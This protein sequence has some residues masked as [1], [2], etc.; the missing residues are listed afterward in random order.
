MNSV[1]QTKELAETYLNGVRGAIPAA[2]LQ[3]AVI[4][5][6]VG[7]WCRTPATILDLG[8][9]D[10]ILGGFLI[11]IFPDARAVFVDFSDP[12]LEAA[13]NKLAG[14]RKTVIVKADY[15]EPDWVRAVAGFK[16]FDLIVSG[17]SIHHQPDERK[18]ALYAELFELLATDAVFLNLEHVASRNPSGKRLFDEFFIDHLYEYHVRSNPETTREAVALDF[19]ARPDKKENILAPVDEQCRWLEEIGFSD[20]D[21]FF[22]I[23]E[24]ALFGGRK[25]AE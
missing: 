24:L 7:L 8:C 9:G 12:M 20:V 1:W 21:C 23:F 17:F 22:K 15:G 5:K 19:Y 2:D 3:L 25:P 11:E 13:G 18:K 4:G 6:I 14:T 10:G 16:P